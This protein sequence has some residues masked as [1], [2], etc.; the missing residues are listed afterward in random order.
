MINF[1]TSHD[2]FFQTNFNFI[3][4]KI[5]PLSRFDFFSFSIVSVDASKTSGG[6]G[7]LNVKRFFLAFR[8]TGSLL[9][10]YTK[11][12]ASLFGS[13]GSNTSSPVSHSISLR[14]PCSPPWSPFRS[15]CS[16]STDTIFG[17]FTR[18]PF[19]GEVTLIDRLLVDGFRSRVKTADPLLKCSNWQTFPDFLPTVV[20]TAVVTASTV[21]N[22]TSKSLKVSGH[23]L[24]ADSPIT[25]NARQYK[26]V[27]SVPLV[28]L[29]A[30][31]HMPSVCMK[32]CSWVSISFFVFLI[33]FIFSRSRSTMIIIIGCTRALGKTFFVN[34]ILTNFFYCFR[35]LWWI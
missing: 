19:R 18:A 2:T 6:G 26:K 3:Y 4:I 33:P 20:E 34:S 24:M 27:A 23:R 14:P 1:M 5:I 7:D 10:E 30:F 21:S 12:L 17:R 28:S 32:L 22:G 29:V 15:D 31:N 9:A 16:S 35:C 25:I 11:M 8:L 13:W